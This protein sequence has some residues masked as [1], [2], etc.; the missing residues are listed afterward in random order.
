M[1]TA[2]PLKQ[3]IVNDL[4]VVVVF[5]LALALSLLGFSQISQRSLHGSCVVVVVVAVGLVVAVMV[6]L[7]SIYVNDP[8]P[9][10]ID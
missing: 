10:V 4:V 6:V 2:M 8:R 1:L 5:A 3:G 9:G 7:S